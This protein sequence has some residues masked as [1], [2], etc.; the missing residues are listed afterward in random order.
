MLENGKT[1]RSAISYLNPDQSLISRQKKLKH[2]DFYQPFFVMLNIG[3]LVM[4]NKN[5]HFR[6]FVD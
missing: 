2:I 5:I 6:I 1:G 4:A 3:A